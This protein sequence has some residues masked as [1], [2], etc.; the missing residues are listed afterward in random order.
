MLRS[1][2]LRETINLFIQTYRLI[3]YPTKMNAID[4]VYQPISKL[5]LSKLINYATTYLLPFSHDSKNMKISSLNFSFKVIN[6]KKN[7]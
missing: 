5:Y 2:F 4:K 6:N 3:C 1:P 7:M